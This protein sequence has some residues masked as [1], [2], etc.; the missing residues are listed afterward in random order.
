MADFDGKEQTVV[1]GHPLDSNS[2]LPARVSER[3]PEV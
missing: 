3:S 2:T 1:D